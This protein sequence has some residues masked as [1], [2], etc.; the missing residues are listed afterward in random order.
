M[1]FVYMLLLGVMGAGAVIADEVKS[2]SSDRDAQISLSSSNAVF[3]LP[4]EPQRFSMWGGIGAWGGDVTYRIGGTVKLSDGTKTKVNDP[5]SE[6]K[7]PLDVAVLAGGGRWVFQQ[8][9]EGFAEG[10]VSISDPS[11]KMEDSDWTESWAPNYKTIYSESDTEL[12]AYALDSG[13]RVW[14]IN[15]RMDTQGTFHVGLGAGLIYQYM[16]WK[17]TTTE[18]WTLG[19]YDTFSDAATYLVKLVIPGR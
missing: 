15:H 18:Q 14:I 16:D 3:V 19:Q 17:T 9:F 1:K 10:M 11:S 12:N 6:L 7:W 4:I 8:R 5:L 13:M 2:N